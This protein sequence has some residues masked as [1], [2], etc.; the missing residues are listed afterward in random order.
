MNQLIQGSKEWKEWRRSKAG[1]SDA[2]I[3]MN[4]SPWMTP[5]E[6]WMEKCGFKEFDHTN[7]VTQIGSEAEPFVR[8]AYEKVTGISFDP[9]VVESDDYPFMSASLD[10]FNADHGII[11]EIKVPGKEVYELAL[12]EEVHT[13]YVWQLE[14]QLLVT[15]AKEVHFVCA[16]VEKDQVNQTWTV[17]DMAI[18]KYKSDPAKRELLLEKEKEFWAFVITKQPPPLTDR[19]SLERTEKDVMELYEQMKSVLIEEKKLKEQLK[20]FE[21]QKDSLK[22]RM[23]LL[24]KHTK[25]EACGVRLQKTVSRRLD[26]KALSE[27]GISPEPFKKEIVTYR[28]TLLE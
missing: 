1:S 25:E 16:K 19:D 5:T 6:L 17:L 11:L 28:V 24:M 18:V 15:G 20:L 14:H 12:K 27:A 7:F 2:P 13:K 21:E 8:Q 4:E 9:L 22:E 3:V 10:G 26:E 23:I